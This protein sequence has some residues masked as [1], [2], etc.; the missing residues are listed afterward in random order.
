MDNTAFQSSPL[1]SPRYGLRFQRYPIDMVKLVTGLMV[2]KLYTS[3]YEF[4]FKVVS[5][6]LLNLFM[7]IDEWQLS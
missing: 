4:G 6:G 1:A 2:F 5:L 7:I 3:V